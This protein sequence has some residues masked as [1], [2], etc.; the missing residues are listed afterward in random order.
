MLILVCLFYSA[1]HL[2]SIQTHHFEKQSFEFLGIHML[3]YLW[4]HLSTATGVVLP[5]F[6]HSSYIS[7]FRFVHL[8][9]WI[10]FLPYAKVF[11]M[12]SLLLRVLYE[13]SLKDESNPSNNRKT[14]L[15]DIET[16]QANKKQ[17]SNTTTNNNR[18]ESEYRINQRALRAVRQTF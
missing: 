11:L 17:N 7:T 18:K 12:R 14:N 8:L 10:S 2:Y 6:L 3:Q 4:V 15:L 5:Y 13:L 16:Q 1:V 9:E